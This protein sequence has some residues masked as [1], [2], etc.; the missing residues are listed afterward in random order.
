MEEW[1]IVSA[2]EFIELINMPIEIK[3]ETLGNLNFRRIF[4]DD[5][6]FIRNCLNDDMY[7]HV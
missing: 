4:D 6:L 1:R 3:S 2:E 7:H 5:F